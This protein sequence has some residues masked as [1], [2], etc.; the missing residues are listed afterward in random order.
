[1]TDLEKKVKEAYL[2]HFKATKV[3]ADAW[4]RTLDELAPAF[5]R[6][7]SDADYEVRK[8]I[9]NA[10]WKIHK[11]AALEAGDPTALAVKGAMDALRRDNVVERAIEEYRDALRIAAETAGKATPKGTRKQ[12]WSPRNEVENLQK[13]LSDDELPDLNLYIEF[14]DDGQLYHWTIDGPSFYR[15]HSGP[16]GVVSL[17][18][19]LD[20]DD[21]ERAVEE[22]LENV[23]FEEEPDE[24]SEGG[25]E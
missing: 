16:M 14:A 7:M 8:N 2:R 20:W 5:S 11:G 6:E 17:S 22:G 18:E 24:E 21:I 1:V 25:E 23:D 12:D 13:Q 4:N 15:G 9:G 3:F 19:S 10:L